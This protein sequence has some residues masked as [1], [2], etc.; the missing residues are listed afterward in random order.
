VSFSPGGARLATIA[1]D[2]VVRI[3]SLGGSPGAPVPR[4]LTRIEMPGPVRRVAIS[5]DDRYLA[6][7]GDDGTLRVWD[8]SSRPD[9]PLPPQFVAFARERPDLE[10]GFSPGDETLVAL[11]SP[12]FNYLS[13]HPVEPK[14][15][16][17]PWSKPALLELAGQRASRNLDRTE[18]ETYLPGLPYRPTV[19]SLPVGAGVDWRMVPNRGWQV[20]LVVLLAAGVVALFLF[21]VPAKFSRHWMDR[22]QWVAYAIA[23][24]AAG[25]VWGWLTPPMVWTDVLSVP[26]LIEKLTVVATLGV[27]ALLCIWGQPK[28][29]ARYSPIETERPLEALV[30]WW[31]QVANPWLAARLDSPDDPPLGRSGRV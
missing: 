17:L 20:P 19:P 14:L 5:H 28:L 22:G 30:A 21:V 4:L 26:S 15:D 2:Q 29:I 6:A 23:L 7:A 12:A 13:G 24:L 16:L 1:A 8:L 31:W 3:W 11:S 27:L 18:W 9:D 25:A 10:I